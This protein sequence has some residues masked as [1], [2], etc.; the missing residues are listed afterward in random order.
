M[1]PSGSSVCGSMWG[2]RWGLLY[3]SS[4]YHHAGFCHQ[5]RS[6]RFL[7]RAGLASTIFG[8]LGDLPELQLLLCKDILY[9]FQA[10]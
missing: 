1:E 10:W 7:A 8:W 5:G 2:L 4:C 9:F 6:S 3:S